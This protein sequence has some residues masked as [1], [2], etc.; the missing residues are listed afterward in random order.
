MLAEA[1]PWPLRFELAFAPLINRLKPELIHV[2]DYRMI[3]VG[4]R[5]A[6]RARA[7]GRE[8]PVLYDAHEFVPGLLPKNRK[9]DVAQIAHEREYLPYTD[10]VVTVSP[11][12]AEL[13]VET[14]ALAER[15]TVVLNSPPRP[16]PARADWATPEGFRDVRAACGLGTATPLMVYCGGATPQRGLHLMVDA[17][18]LEPDLHAAF[19]VNQLT[20]PYPDSLI[21]QAERLGA[22]DRLHFLPY[23]PYDVL[24][25]F[26]AT[27]DVG[28]HPLE[29]GPAN[30][31]V[32]LSTKFFEFMHAGL[33]VVVSNVK[34][35]SEEVQRLGIG[36]VFSYGDAA[37]LARAVRAVLDD[38][39][40]YTKPYADP[41]FLEEF[42]WEAQA[43]RYDAVYR[44]LLDGSI[45][46]GMSTVA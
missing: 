44:R 33:P 28:V 38:R 34:A 17:L 4:V 39:P 23:V 16:D 26:L 36:E 24:T 43:A 2:H 15:P 20:G 6:A 12:L 10:G 40:R 29:T 46:S 42:T 7:A 22:A 5:A 41:G 21:E 25:S 9:W 1:R 8:V 32:A 19:V 14:H 31:E 30:H 27:A 35:M 11:R 18:E 13:L 45:R 37:G 3:G